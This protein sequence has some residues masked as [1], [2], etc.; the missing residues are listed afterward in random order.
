MEQG[1]AGRG[2]EGRRLQ[3]SGVRLWGVFF[4][5]FFSFFS[6][7]SVFSVFSVFSSFSCLSFF[8]GFILLYSLF[9]CLFGTLL[10]ASLVKKLPFSSPHTCP[11]STTRPVEWKSLH[12]LAAIAR[13]MPP[14]SWNPT[15]RESYQGDYKRSRVWFSCRLD[16]YLRHL[17]FHLSVLLVFFVFFPFFSLRALFLLC[18]PPFSC[19]CHPPFSINS[20]SPL[21]PPHPPL[22]CSQ[23]RSSCMAASSVSQ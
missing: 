11:A 14:A 10:V 12:P 3:R 15:S 16:L 8:G 1:Q 19:Q 23:D 7:F 4:S 2:D 18:L 9:P 22:A 6:F 5:F 13:L 17:S 20:A 21:G